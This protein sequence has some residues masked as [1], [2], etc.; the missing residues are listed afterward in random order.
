MSFGRYP[1]S[2]K[3]SNL[4]CWKS[5]EN[6]FSGVIQ[7]E[8]NNYI[9]RENIINMVIALMTSIPTS[10]VDTIIIRRKRNNNNNIIIINAKIIVCAMTHITI[11]GGASRK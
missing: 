3:E 5:E 9:E 10:L 11:P 4:C 8:Q 1:P 7:Q 2:A 6:R